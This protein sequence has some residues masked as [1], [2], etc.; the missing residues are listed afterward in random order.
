MSTGEC[1][2]A[3]SSSRSPLLIS[4]SGLDSNVLSTLAEARVTKVQHFLAWPAAELAKKTGLSIEIIR[5]TASA[6]HARFGSRPKT[7]LEER[8]LHRQCTGTS[9]MPAHLKGQALTTLTGAREGD[10]VELVGPPGCGKT[11]HA[12][13]LAAT[14]AASGKGVVM[15]DTSAAISVDRIVQILAAFGLPIADIESTLNRILIIPAG[16][17]T[18]CEQVLAALINDKLT[19]LAMSNKIAENITSQA[20]TVVRDVGLVVLDSGASLLAPALG[21]KWEDGWSGVAFSN[22]LSNQVRTLANLTQATVVLT[23]RQARRNGGELRA[24]LGRSWAYFC[25]RRIY[26]EV[27]DVGEGLEEDDHFVVI[28]RRLSK[29]HGTEAPKKALVGLTGVHILD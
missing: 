29:R 19:V 5:E 9:Y 28:Q 21:W 26:L 12:L 20:M 15:I 23:N 17:A 14:V 7:A 3:Q 4:V 25:D 24:A 11:Q 10:V 27:E 2:P 18:R 16:T 8:D 6:V 22:A 13:T 1:L